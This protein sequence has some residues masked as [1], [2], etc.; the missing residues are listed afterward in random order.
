MRAVKA[1][2]ATSLE[3]G[4]ECL[5]NPVVESQVINRQAAPLCAVLGYVA[6]MKQSGIASYVAM[7]WT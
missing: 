2:L 5:P 7:I 6:V 1:N 4:G 3:E